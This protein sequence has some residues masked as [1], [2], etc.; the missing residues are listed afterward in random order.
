LDVSAYCRVRLLFRQ[1]LEGIQHE[2][3]KDI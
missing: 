2:L 3:F 1:I